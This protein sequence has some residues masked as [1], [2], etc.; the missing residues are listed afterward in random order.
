MSLLQYKDASRAE[1]WEILQIQLEETQR[2]T[3][4]RDELLKNQAKRDLEMKLDELKFLE[5]SLI[6]GA[7][8]NHWCE[9]EQKGYMW[10]HSG[11]VSR[12]KELTKQAEG[13]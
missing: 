2:L 10:C 6:T 4:E 8:V 13:G 5:K 11:I 9:K 12:I 3:A 1:L 7:V